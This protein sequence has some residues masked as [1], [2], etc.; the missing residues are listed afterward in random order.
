V[1]LKDTLRQSKMDKSTIS[2]QTVVNPTVH[3]TK[4][5]TDKPIYFEYPD[6][7]SAVFKQRHLDFSRKEV[8]SKINETSRVPL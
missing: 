3:S 8:T 5:L 7:K 1:P 2:K 6:S 4:D